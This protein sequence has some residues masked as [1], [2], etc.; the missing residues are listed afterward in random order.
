M[1]R[2]LFSNAQEISF[3]ACKWPNRDGAPPR[4]RADFR[5]GLLLM[6]QGLESAISVE[7][8]ADLIAFL[9]VPP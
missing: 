7:Q 4:H 6:P 2:S 5:L 8:I 3:I 9:L 1:G